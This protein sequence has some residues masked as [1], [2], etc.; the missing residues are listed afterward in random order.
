M[1]KVLLKSNTLLDKLLSY[2]KEG[3]A[4]LDEKQKIV[5]EEENRIK[6]EKEEAEK[7]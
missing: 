2:A 1:N 7:K 4:I 5:T 3:G 6:K